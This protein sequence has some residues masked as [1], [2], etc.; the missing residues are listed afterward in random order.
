[1]YV[2]EMDSVLFVA[3]ET[4]MHYT[5]H[6]FLELISVAAPRKSGL[7]DLKKS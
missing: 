4:V 5:H 7:K 6:W 2:D 1:M 3:S